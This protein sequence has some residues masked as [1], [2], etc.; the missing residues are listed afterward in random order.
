MTGDPVAKP[1]SSQHSPEPGEQFFQQSIADLS[2]RL[3][4]RAGKSSDDVS[5][6]AAEERRRAMQ[7]YDRD[8]ARRWR[9]MLAGAGA[10]VV[11]AGIAWFVVLLGQPEE[12]S[13]AIS[14]PVAAV[15]PAPTTIAAA[16]EPAAPSTQSPSI[17]SGEPALATL[18]ATETTPAPVQEPSPP[19]AQ[20]AAAPSDP[21]PQAVPEAAPVPLPTLP[22][23]EIREVQKRLRGFGFDPGPIDGVAG[24]QTEIATQHYLEARGQPQLPPTD[25]QLLDQLR[26][27]ST[28]P[29]VQRQEPQ[30]Q[31]A[32]RSGWS[33]APAARTQSAQAGRGQ[34]DPFQ[35]V[36][37]A[38][39]HITQ[40]LQTVFR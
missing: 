32:Q 27:D 19:P 16:A 7:A 11:T 6:V 23:G 28:P 20:A 12:V 10:L 2:R 39:S 33:G 21:T 31:V 34:F 26:Q 1:G 3:S 13:P 36:K 15:Q 22:R 4:E 40:W 38:G 30:P 25:P 29:A 17:Q 8:H 9:L 18:T 14:A 5:Q 37:Y 35:P 24:R